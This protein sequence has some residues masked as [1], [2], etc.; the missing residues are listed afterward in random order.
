MPTHQNDHD[1]TEE[2]IKDKKYVC[3]SCG[4]ESHIAGYCPIDD[5]NYMK[6]VCECDSGS[7]ASEC[8]EPELEEQEKMMEQEIEQEFADELDQ[9]MRESMTQE[10]QEIEDEEKFF[11][12][13]E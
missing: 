4:F 6:K 5:E 13:E 2:H 1:H 8:C 3:P 10:A 11:E 7:Y 9:E 12:N